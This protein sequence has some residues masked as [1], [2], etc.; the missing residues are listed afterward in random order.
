[1]NH[2]RI[3]EPSR[4]V[5]AFVEP[6]AKFGPGD[7][8]NAVALFHFII[9]HVAIFV[10][11]VHHHA[12]GHHGDADFRFVLLE[13]FLRLVRAVKRLA[14]GVLAR[15][16][17]VAA[18]D[19]VRAAMILADQRVPDRLARSTHT[20]GKREE[21][22]LLRPLRVL[23]TQQL[24]ATHARVVVHIAGLGHTDHRVD[25]KVRFDLLGGAEGEFDVRAVH[26][27]AGL[28]GYD[29]APSEAGKFST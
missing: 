9:G 24:I 17:M 14:V 21:R 8:Q 2:F 5:A 25:Q 4:N 1:M 27:I 28:E 16:G 29:T 12:E 19:Q 23:R 15:T 7:V 6:L 18:H 10:L 3:G 22:E 20:H 11:E 26:R 13:E